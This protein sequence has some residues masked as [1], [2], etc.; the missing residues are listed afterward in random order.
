MNKTLLISLGLLFARALSAQ[1]WISYQLNGRASLPGNALKDL[2]FTRTGTGGGFA[3]LMGKEAMRLR[4]RLD[5]DTFPGSGSTRDL[6]TYGLGAEGLLNLA[7]DSDFHP[8]LSAGLAVQKWRLGSQA[9]INGSTS[10]V[11]MATRVEAGIQYKNRVGVYVGT[12]TGWVG[13]GR[14]ARC[15]Y[16]GISVIVY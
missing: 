4:V 10:L 7:P 2:G 12:L 6:N 13:W 8:T 14:R 5:T 3:V 9:T 15:P 1:D 16:V 11:R